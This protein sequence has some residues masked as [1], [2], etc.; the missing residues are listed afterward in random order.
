MDAG[1]GVELCN[2][3][4][5]IH[6]VSE[7]MEEL[8]RCI[9]DASEKCGVRYAGSYSDSAPEMKSCLGL[10]KPV[11]VHTVQCWLHIMGYNQGVPIQEMLNTMLEGGPV[12]AGDWLCHM[13]HQSR[14]CDTF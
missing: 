13:S 8:R 7:Y 14:L 10:D 3:W 4:S 12:T 9:G 2:M 11:S 5:P 1:G 6:N